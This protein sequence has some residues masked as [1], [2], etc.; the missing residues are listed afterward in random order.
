MV[1]VEGHVVANREPVVESI[2]VGLVRRA[3]ARQ[4]FLD[5]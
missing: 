5:S 2:Q 3:A 1:D 4:C